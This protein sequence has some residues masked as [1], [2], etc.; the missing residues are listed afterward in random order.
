MGFVLAFLSALCFSITNIILKKGMH[1]SEHNGVWII[2]FINML[3][4]GI[5]LLVSIYLLDV[6]ISLHPLGLTIFILSGIFINVFGR[7]LLY[8]G[9]RHIGSSKAVA[10]KNSAPIITFIFAIVVINEQITMFPFIGIVLIFTG[11]ILLG[12]QFFHQSSQQIYK[13]G[14]VISL[15]SAFGYGIGQGMSKQAM[16]YVPNPFL[17]VFV[18]ILAAFVVLTII[19]ASRGKIRKHLHSARENPY[20]I[21]AGVTTSL[22]LLFFYLSVSYIPVSYAVAILAVDPVLT[23]ILVS[24]FMKKEESVSKLVVF[25]ATIVFLGAVIISLTG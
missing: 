22:A 15:L 1:H 4:L 18:G 25:V 16:E 8:M 9:I 23:V 12:I 2:T 10:I 24:F 7:G 11:L 20:Y 14:Y 17:G 13:L 6:P 19:E 3:I 21:W 5:I